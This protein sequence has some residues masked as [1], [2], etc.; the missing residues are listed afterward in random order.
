M[1]EPI[2]ILVTEE[3]QVAQAQRAAK[4]LAES[5]GFEQVA[6]YATATSASELASN[7]VRHAS[8]GG[9]ITLTALERKAEIGIEVIAEDEGPGILD[10][11]R[12][13]QDGVSTAG[14]LGGGLAAVSRLMDEFEI[15]SA[16]GVGT[17]IVARRWQTCK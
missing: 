1:Q 12:A 6:V 13:M 17:R 7:L 4:A 3:Y 2:I 10:L 8:R 16:L 5:L 15:S 14:G 9:T 11:E